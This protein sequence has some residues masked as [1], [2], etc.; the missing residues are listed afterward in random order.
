[1]AD[2]IGPTNREKFSARITTMQT[3]TS[4]TELNGG[5]PEGQSIQSNLP[6]SFTPIELLL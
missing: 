4:S 6:A 2:L 1:M 5:R 3:Q